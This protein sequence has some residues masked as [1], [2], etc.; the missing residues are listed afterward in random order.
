MEF[1]WDT[2]V[3]GGH[4]RRF[5]GKGTTSKEKLRGSLELGS[6]GDSKKNMYDNFSLHLELCEEQVKDKRDVGN[7]N[8]NIKEIQ[9][10]ILIISL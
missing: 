5:L 10:I 2:W 8:N 4:G 9:M 3:S 6:F 1:D 7:T